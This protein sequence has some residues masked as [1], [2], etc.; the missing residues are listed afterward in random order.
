MPSLAFTR[1]LWSVTRCPLADLTRLALTA[2]ILAV[3]LGGITATG[4]PDGTADLPAA[5]PAAALPNR[6]GDAPATA[7]ALWPGNNESTLTLASTRTRPRNDE[8]T[9]TSSWNASALTSSWNASALFSSWNTSA[10]FS[11]D[12]SALVSPVS[13]VHAAAVVPHSE[14]TDAGAVRASARPAAVRLAAGPGEPT[15]RGPPTA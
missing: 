4:L 14:H 8:S 2:L 1:P 10:L 15:R 9:L 7:R 5:P 13:V 11:R 3:G 12:E 6:P